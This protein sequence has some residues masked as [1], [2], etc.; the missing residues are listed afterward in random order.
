LFAWY[1]I[2][3]IVLR[4]I[5]RGYF[6]RSGTA[7]SA[8]D[9]S[10]SR[11]PIDDEGTKMSGGGVFKRCRVQVI[12]HRPAPELEL[13]TAAGTQPWKLVLRLRALLH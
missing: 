12:E 13:S 5:T 11:Y 1:K 10:S 6:T 2:D 7:P 9:Q 8:V 3:C 4:R